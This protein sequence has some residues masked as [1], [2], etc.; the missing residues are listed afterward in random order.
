MTKHALP[1]VDPARI[2][3]EFA[4]TVCACQECTL[5]CQ[6]LPGYLIPADLDR[7]HQHLAPGEDLAAWAHQHLR[8]S[9]GAQ[10]MRHGSLFRIRTLVPARQPN[11]ACRF[12][13]ADKRCAIHAIAPYGC[14]FFDSHMAGAEADR[15][16]TRGLQAVLE[17]W[18]R[19]DLYPQLWVALDQSG[20]RAPAPEIC[21]QQLRQAAARP[22]DV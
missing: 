20:L 1:L 8:A 18:S 2:E 16:S 14:S 11:G 12:L 21:R 17:A 4:R 3:F 15:R 6:Y 7:I 22:S 13:T 5:N 19:G 9:P 10:V